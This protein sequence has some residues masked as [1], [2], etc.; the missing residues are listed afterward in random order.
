MH[1]VLLSLGLAV[2]A[3]GCKGGGKSKT[4]AG[5]DDAVKPASCEPIGKSVA[6]TGR[7]GCAGSQVC[8]ESGRYG[9][10]DCG[11]PGAKPTNDGGASVSSDAGGSTGGMM[12]VQCGAACTA[13]G[14]CGGGSCAIE[15]KGMQTVEGLGTVTRAR[16]PGGICS[17]RPL[18]SVDSTQ[19]CDPDAVGAAQGCGSCGVCVYEQFSNA[20]TS[21][22]REKCTPS[23]TDNGCTRDEYTCSFVTGACLDGQC[24]KDDECRVYTED[25]DGDG[26]SDAF[27]FDTMSQ[28]KCNLATRRC[29]VAGKAGAQAGDPCMR[30]DDCEA[31]GYCLT[32]SSGEFDVP[33]RGGYCVKRGC[34]VAGLGCSGQGVCGTPR[35]WFED[36]TL[37]TVCARGCTLGTEPTAEQLGAAGHGAGCRAGYMC[38]WGGAD[39]D[40]KGTC[41]PGNYNAVTTNNVGTACK[42]HKECYSPFGHGRC[43]SMG[44]DTAS[45]SFCAIFDCGTPGL[46]GDVCGTGNLCVALDDTLSACLKQCTDAS[47]CP[48]TMAC[49]TVGTNSKAC[50]FG[51]A[52]NA[53]CKTGETCSRTGA[54]VKS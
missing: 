33:Y 28:A 35:A 29:Q 36:E 22:C 52:S 17:Q 11:E 49:S 48:P 2:L 7:G 30:D 43:A 1:A 18:T 45:A 39:K 3:L 54:C 25:S 41:L 46:P 8:E 37:G 27:V 13:D 31:D 51:C 23:A 20:L 4:D 6:C 16:F 12:T 47:T 44:T 32:E 5:A 42:E 38:M 14:D 15:R 50:V 26:L 53:E 19:A 24:T 21:V 34:K 40:P 9:T 10:C